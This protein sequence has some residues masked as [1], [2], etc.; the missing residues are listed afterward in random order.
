[1]HLG[2]PKAEH[3]GPTCP[4]DWKLVISI[5]RS[6][7]YKSWVSHSGS[8]QV[9]IC[10]DS[11][12]LLTRHGK[13]PLSFFCQ[14]LANRLDPTSIPQAEAVRNRT[15]STASKATASAIVETRRLYPDLVTISCY[16]CHLTDPSMNGGLD[17]ARDMVW[18]LIGQLLRKFPR[19]SLWIPRSAYQDRRRS[20]VET[21][22]ML[23]VFIIRQYPPNC[24][25]FFFI[26]QV[27]LF[28]SEQFSEAEVIIGALSELVGHDTRNTDSSILAQ[29]DGSSCPFSPFQTSGPV[30]KLMLTSSTTPPRTIMAMFEDPNSFI[31]VDTLPEAPSEVVEALR[32]DGVGEDIA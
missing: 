9:L 10:S 12:E 5:L 32:E 22:T 1:M 6:N 19:N 17:A 26:D 14:H 29:L 2:E 11:G 25:L 28:E 7:S 15:A 4:E 16:C 8:S 13:S 24:T 23:L 21:L 3:L 31:D 20:S 30:V 27:S 18:G